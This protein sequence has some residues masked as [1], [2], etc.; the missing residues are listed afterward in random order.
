[1]SA[2]LILQNAGFETAS[3][4]IPSFSVYKD[5]SPVEVNFNAENNKEKLNEF[6]LKFVNTPTETNSA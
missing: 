5:G 4:T 2:G 1:V 3:L 6:I